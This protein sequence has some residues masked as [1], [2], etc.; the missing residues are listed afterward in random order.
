MGVEVMGY[1][2]L[3]MY[4]SRWEG[5]VCGVVS[6]GIR[7]SKIKCVVARGEGGLNYLELKQ[8][9]LLSCT[10]LPFHVSSVIFSG[11]GFL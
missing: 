3:G 6:V 7:I 11:I 10:P 5:Y 4:V 1:P 9:T 2:L 8:K